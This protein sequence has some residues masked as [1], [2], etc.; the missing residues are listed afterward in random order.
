MIDVEVSAEIPT[1]ETTSEPAEIPSVAP[2]PSPRPR[3]AEG[4]DA[5]EP[6][7][8][9]SDTATDHDADA[10]E[11]DQ[12]EAGKARPRSRLYGWLIGAL[13]LVCAG[14]AVVAALAGSAVLRGHN[15]DVDRAAATDA[16]RTEVI[17]VL[18]IDPKTVDADVQRIIDGS[19]G[20]FKN[21]FTSRKDVFTSVVKEQ[22]VT[23]TGQVRAI[24]VESASDSQASVL[25]AATSSVTN[26]ASSGQPQARDYRIRVQLQKEAG[27]WLAAQIEFV[28]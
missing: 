3:S 1:G 19:T 25:V 9:G 28:P 10:S 8:A 15:D 11:R 20:Q 6:S 21:D 26:S 4:D 23:S 22:N 27:H 5:Q 17:N 14:L 16:A 7:A 24:G 2:R 12:D 13:L 18:T